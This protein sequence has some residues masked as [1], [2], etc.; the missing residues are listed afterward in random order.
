MNSIPFEYQVAGGSQLVRGNSA[1]ALDL[2]QQLRHNDGNLFYSP[3]SISTALAMTFAGARGNTETEMAQTLHFELEPEQLHET[4]AALEN[5]LNA[6]QEGGDVLLSVANAL[7]PQVGYDFLASFLDIVKQFYGV[8]ITHLDY[9]NPEAARVQ[10]NAWVEEETQ[11]KI[12]NLIP[13]GMLDSLTML[14]LTNAIYFKGDWASPFSIKKTKNAL[15]WLTPDRAVDAPLMTKKRSFR[16]GEIDNL[17]ILELPYVGDEIS[18]LVL[19]PRA[20]DGLAELEGA[21]THENLRSWTNRIW[22]REVE[23][24]LPKFKLS[25]SFNLGGTL[26]RNG[27]ERRFR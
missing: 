26:G 4:L 14:V 22:E 3:Y 20:V 1:F 6:V 5:R 15:F 11:G 24:H 18:M 16:Y 23:V 13:S 19:L 25:S 27:H 8:S 12:K 21:L 7:W 10:I 17:Q 9:R 2:Y